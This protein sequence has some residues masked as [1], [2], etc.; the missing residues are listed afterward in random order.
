MSNIQPADEVGTALT[1]RL[2]SLSEASLTDGGISFSDM[3]K[4]CNRCVE[5]FGEGRKY[6]GTKE[7]AYRAHSVFSCKSPRILEIKLKLLIKT[8]TRGLSFSFD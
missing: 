1:L 3:L 5:E 2:G 7:V 6:G 8:K 4:Q